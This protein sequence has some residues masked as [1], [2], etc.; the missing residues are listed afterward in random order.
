MKYILEQSLV[1]IA[2]S[3][4]GGKYTSTQV[5]EAFIHKIQEVNPSL[6][7]VVVPRFEEALEEAKEADRLFSE[8]QLKGRLHGV[9]ITV[10]ECLDLKGTPSTFGLIRRKN[11]IPDKND[12]Y[13]QALID[14]GAI[15]IGKT[16]V[17]Q[18]IAY[19]ES[20]NPLYGR[21]NNPINPA[22][23]CGGSSG[24]EGAIIKAGGSLVGLGTDLGG[25][26]RIPAA[27]CGIL[28]LKP[29]MHRNYDFAR[30]IDDVEWKMICS[31]T[32]VLG[33][34]VE[35]V[36]LVG[37]IIGSIPSPFN[38]TPRP[39][40]DYNLV[41]IHQLK[42][43]YYLTDGLFEPTTEI[44]RGILETVSYL[45]SKGIHCKE[46]KAYKHEEAEALH[47]QI[48]SM[49]GAKLFMDNLKGDQ[50]TKQIAPLVMI[51]KLPKFISRII[52]FIL[53]LLGQK[54]A[55]RLG[56]SFGKTPQNIMTLEKRYHD[57]VEAYKGMMKAEDID[58]IISPV[59]SMHA[60][61]HGK[62]VDL[63]SGGTYTLI[64][65][66]TGFPS[67]VVPV[68]T[69]A[70]KHII[71]RKRTLEI[72]NNIARKTELLSD[73]LSVS[74]QI[75]ALPWKEDHVLAMM[76]EILKKKNTSPK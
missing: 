36:A 17:S 53:G 13:I 62:S 31:V 40:P 54:S 4:R 70:A 41:D 10:K 33:K 34:H 58:V 20:D 37:E 2:Q 46:I 71:P 30:I 16:N 21:T 67:G 55:S 65:N 32:G 39:F 18:L 56:R 11:D 35:D 74:V 24:G 28:G 64:H 23:T 19:L 59:N 42:V 69:V 27:F 43:G 1:Q 8:D 50:P 68:S 44:K 61:L 7:A 48:N 45:Q 12:P 14:E 22:F 72:A 25:S 63:G 9:P 49:D 3:I 38:H 60:Y 73:G 75:T 47:T 51:M 6:N 76:E 57:Y 52:V 15:V 26:V 29:T 5:V 66:V